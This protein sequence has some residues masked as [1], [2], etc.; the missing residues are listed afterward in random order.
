MGWSVG[1]RGQ[2]DQTLGGALIGIG[3]LTYEPLTSDV[4]RFPGARRRR[5]LSRESGFDVL[6]VALPGDPLRPSPR[7][8]PRPAPHDAGYMGCHEDRGDQ[9]SPLTGHYPPI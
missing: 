2:P 3:A 1:R 9:S 4:S 8:L 6:G 7:A 5:R